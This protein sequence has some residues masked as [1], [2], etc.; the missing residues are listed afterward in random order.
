MVSELIFHSKQGGEI[1]RP[2]LP[3]FGGSPAIPEAVQHHRELGPAGSAGGVQGACRGA[4]EDAL[5]HRPGHGVG[6]PAGDLAAD[7]GAHGGSAAE[8]VEHHGQLL[9]GD[10][11]L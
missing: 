7:G 3:G 11:G 4:A 5:G 9:P 10:G 8:A 2:A 6:G 1:L